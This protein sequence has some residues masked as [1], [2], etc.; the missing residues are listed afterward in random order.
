MDGFAKLQTVT[1]QNPEKRVAALEN[2]EPENFQPEQQAALLT[3]F[4]LANSTPF[5]LPQVPAGDAQ[6]GAKLVEQLGCRGCHNISAPN[7]ENFEHKNRAS[8][9]DHGPDL[10]N[11]GSKASPE[12]IF[13][14]LKNPKAYAPETRMP[15]L[16]L[17]D[18][19]A[20]NITT[21]LAGNKYVKGEG[22][23]LAPREYAT[24]AA[25]KTDNKDYEVLGKKLLRTYGC[26]GC[27]YVKGFETTPGIG[28]ELTE[29]GNKEVPRLDFGDY[30]VNHSEQSWES[31][32]DN[33]LKHPRV[34]RYER[35]DT[36]MPQF[37]LC[38]DP[39]DESPEKRE[40]CK[41][42]ENEVESIMVV[43]K[44]MRG[45]TK[46]S[47]LLGHK[48]SEA[49]QVRE[50]GRELV[51]TYN[52]YGCHT[53]DGH[54]GDI[55]QMQQY[56]SED[57][58]RFAPPVIVGEG[59]KT[60]PGWLFEFLKAPIKLR[61]HLAVRMPTFGLH[62]DQA[63]TLVGMFSA[64]DGAEYP[65]RDYRGY[66]LEGARKE[67]ANSAFKAAQCTQCHTL[68]NEP[69]PDIALK[70]APNLLLS[71]NRLRPEWLARWIRDPQ[72]LYPGVNMPSFF[73][74]GNPLV[75]MAANPMTASMPGAQELSKMEVP[76]LIYL[77][78]DL[79]MTIPAPQGSSASAPAAATP[80]KKA[81]APSKVKHAK[82][83]GVRHASRN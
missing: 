40:D 57:G 25:V 14:W 22:G 9:Y 56:Q 78:R 19:E 72:V 50:K 21:Y 66:V 33:K 79:L 67:Q 6:K 60:Q 77:L 8:H 46:D 20:A 36:R 39:K 15:N 13:A 3:S 16:R 29:F 32:L 4:L 80:A 28:A 68:G 81:A 2:L 26:Y 17:S 41:G 75:G 58:P 7:T 31:W 62:D 69:S 52:C 49:E 71:K 76:E 53:V 44:G 61:P 1:E 70:G 51:R 23:K 42:Q 27:H 5:A 12:W 47:D 38:G 63:T 45:K 54:V 74:G 34:Y 10:G 18:E 64:F 37:D 83:A 30:I 55:R 35:V 73:G 48:L 82:A 11:V 65:Y 59:A 24:N 43:M